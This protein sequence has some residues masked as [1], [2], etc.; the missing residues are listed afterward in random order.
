MLDNYDFTLHT[1]HAVLAVCWC[2]GWGGGE[3][4]KQIEIQQFGSKESPIGGCRLPCRYCRLTAEKIDRY[5]TVFKRLP[6]IMLVVEAEMWWLDTRQLSTE[7]K[8]TQYGGRH[9][10]NA[11]DV[12]SLAGLPNCHC[13]NSVQDCATYPTNFFVP[14]NSYCHLRTVFF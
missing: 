1:G 10:H 5:S 6:N 3:C 8:V 2:G 7:M 14:L 11:I 13:R 12:G 4:R 9:C